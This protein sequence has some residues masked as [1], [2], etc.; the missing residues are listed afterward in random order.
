MAESVLHKQMDGR[1]CH[2]QANGRAFLKNNLSLSLSLSGHKIFCVLK[3]HYQEELCFT[4]IWMAESVIHKQTAVHF[5]KNKISLSLSL[6]LSVGMIFSMYVE[7]TL[8][9]RIC[10]LVGSGWQNLSS[11]NS[12]AFGKSRTPEEHRL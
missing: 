11:A 12:R 8:S 10:A 2:P 4:C 3:A 5:L 7:V 9:C 6:S 1:I